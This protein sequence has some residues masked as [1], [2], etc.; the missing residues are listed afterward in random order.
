MDW[1]PLLLNNF[2]APWIFALVSLCG[3]G[4]RDAWK[5]M[6]HRVELMAGILRGK[7]QPRHHSSCH[8]FLKALALFCVWP[9]DSWRLLRQHYSCKHIN[10]SEDDLARAADTGKFRFQV[11]IHGA[12]KKKKKGFFFLWAKPT[13]ISLAK[14]VEVFIYFYSP[15][16]FHSFLFFINVSHLLFLDSFFP[17]FLASYFSN[18]VH[19]VVQCR[20]GEKSS[21]VW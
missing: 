13:H 7:L 12:V 20:R 1:R 2:P 5:Q 8:T 11:I 6:N 15:L 4:S 3:S 10:T 17:F 18:S 21:L 16:L 19:A 9:Y 14:T